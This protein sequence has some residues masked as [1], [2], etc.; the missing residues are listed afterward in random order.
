[1]QAK[2]NVTK[3]DWALVKANA[4]VKGCRFSVGHSL[5]TRDRIAVALRRERSA[6]IEG[7]LAKLI[8]AQMLPPNLETILEQLA[9]EEEAR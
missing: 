4:V 2:S 7:V 3:L 9:T 6:T 1:M 5:P 8:A